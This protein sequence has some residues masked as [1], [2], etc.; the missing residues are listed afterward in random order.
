MS[1]SPRC[2]VEGRWGGSFALPVA[3]LF[4]VRVNQVL[5]RRWTRETQSGSGLGAYVPGSG[6]GLCSAVRAQV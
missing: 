4:F 2:C 5:V 3:V 6:A 1:V